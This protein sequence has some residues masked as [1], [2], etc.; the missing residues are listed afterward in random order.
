MPTTIV[1]SLDRFWCSSILPYTITPHQNSRRHLYMQTQHPP[2]HCCFFPFNLVVS[3]NFFFLFFE[4]V[5][6]TCFDDTAFAFTTYPPPPPSSSDHISFPPLHLN[7]FRS[8]F[9]SIS[10]ARYLH[11]LLPPPLSL[12]NIGTSGR[13]RF[14]YFSFGFSAALCFADAQ[15]STTS[16]CVFS[17]KQIGG[18]RPVKKSKGL[19]FFIS[20]MP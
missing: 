18:R 4:K 13:T 2:S 9:N 19:L 12:F 7:T 3:F 11:R 17:V 6:S 8:A 10:C 15:P 1:S 20:F 14:T 5:V 16:C